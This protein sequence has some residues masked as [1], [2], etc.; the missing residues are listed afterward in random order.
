[1]HIIDSFVYVSV[2]V[3]SP[4]SAFFNCRMSLYRRT[5]TQVWRT[6]SWKLKL[7]AVQCRLT[8]DKQLNQM[9]HGKFSAGRRGR[10]S[11]EAEWYPRKRAVPQGSWGFIAEKDRQ[12]QLRR[13][14]RKQKG[15]GDGGKGKT[16]SKGGNKDTQRL[17]TVLWRQEAEGRKGGERGDGLAWKQQRIWKEKTDFTAEKPIAC[18]DL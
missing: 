5:I 14:E 6:A 12:S 16:S 11:S 2:P 9:T 13:K 7:E 4:T 8:L 10:P 1:M 17:K 3:Q 15:Y 18:S